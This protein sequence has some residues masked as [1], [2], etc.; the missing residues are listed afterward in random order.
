[1]RWL[2]HVTR[3][4][5]GHIP[6]D[7]LYGELQHGTRQKGRPNLRF[8][9][10]CKRDRKALNININ[11]WETMASD[12]TVWKCTVHEGLAGFEEHL[13]QKSEETR[14]LR[15][16]RS[17]TILQPSNFVCDNCSKDCHSNI[18]LISHKRRC[19]NQP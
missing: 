14:C 3:M 5:D 2:G 12:S 10:I 8:K 4:E 16:E 1:M 17:Q 7:L 15:K 18:G 6:K 19:R 11:T 9:D 13:Y